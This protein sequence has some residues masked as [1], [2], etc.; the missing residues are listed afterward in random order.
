MNE[1]LEL[2]ALPMEAAEYDS[3]FGPSTYSVHC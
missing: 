1:I 2:Q 3:D